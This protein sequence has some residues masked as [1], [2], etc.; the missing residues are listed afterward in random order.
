VEECLTLGGDFMEIKRYELIPNDHDYTL[1]VYLDPQLEEYSFEFGRLK[2]GPENIQQQIQSLIKERYPHVKITAAK[3]MAG[4]MLV[5]TIY[6]GT[7]VINT[8]AATAAVQVEQ[9]VAFDQ[10]TVQSGDTVY[11]IAKKFNVTV[12]SLKAVN[13]LTSNTIFPGQQ[14]KLPYYTYTVVALDTLYSIAKRYNSTPT[15]IQ[16]F[17]QLSSTTL[18]IGQKLRIPRTTLQ[19]TPAAPPTVEQPGTYKVV[20]GDTLY[21]I[22]KRFGVTL[23]QI[24]SLNRLTTNDIF[25]GQTL[26]IKPATTADTVAPSA[27]VMQ[28]PGKITQANSAAFP[29]NGT[30]EP[31]STVMITIS[32]GAQPV[33]TQRSTA[34]ER[35]EFSSFLNVS[36]LPDGNLFIKAKAIDASG[37]ESSE[38]TFT[39]SKDTVSTDPVIDNKQL[40]TLENAREYTIFGLAEPGATVEMTISDGINPAISTKAIVS[41]TG[42]FR[43][44]IDLRSLQDGTLKIVAR[45]IDPYGNKSALTETT[46]IKETSLAAPVIEN[47]GIINLESSGSYMIHGMARPG[48]TVNISVSDGVHPPVKAA[49]TTDQNGEFHIKMDL[50]PLL[51]GKL[52]FSTTQTSVSGIQ[53]KAG[54]IELAK[55]AT[56]P[57]VPI[58]NN[59]NMINRSNQG[60]FLLTGTA[61][62]LAMVTVRAFNENG[63]PIE[64]SVQA[65]ETG[66]YR[67]PLDVSSLLDG[68][69]KFELAQVDGAGNKSL[70]TTKTLKKDTIGPTSIKFAPIPVI[71]SGNVAGYVISGT[72]EPQ[73]SVDMVISDGK[74]KITKTFETD[75]NGKFTLLPMDLSSLTDGNITLTFRA[76]DAA[77]NTGDL[78]P[79]TVIKDTAAQEATINLPAPYV[80]SSTQRAF[81]ISGK[82]VED[83][84]TVNMVISDGVTSVMKSTVVKNG[85]FAEGFDL[86]GLKDGKLTLQVTTTDKAGNTSVVQSNTIEKDTFVGSP[87]VS[88]NGLETRDTGSIFTIIGTAEPKAS[89]TVTLLGTNGERLKSVTTVTND[90][91]FYSIQVPL[92]GLAPV[93]AA[94]MLQTDLAGNESK[95]TSINLYS[96]TVSAGET[97]TAIAKR[98]NTTVYAL[99]SL[100]NLTGDFLAINQTLRLP[101]TASEVVNLGY[102]Y[103]DTS[104]YTDLVSQTSRSINT[105]SPSYFDIN[106]DGTLKLTA[107]IDRNF[108]EKMHAQGI[109]VVPFLSNHWNREVGRAMLANKEL[110][111]TQIADAVARY[112]LDGVH[113]DIENVTHLDRAN[114]TE[115]VR[116]LR[117]KIPASK[118]VSVAVA[119][120]PNGW[121]EGWHGSYDYKSLAKYADYLMIMSYD[122]SYP[123]GE[124]GPVASAPWVERSIQYAINNGVSSDKI[125][126]GMSHFGRYWIAGQSYGGFGISNWQVEDLIKTYNGTVVWDEKSQTPKAVITIKAGDPKRV[127]GGTTLAPGTYTIWFDNDQSIRNK[128]ALVEKYGLRGVGNWSIGQESGGIWDNFAA[129]LPT[130][131]P[132]LA[133]IPVVVPTPAP[134]PEPVPTPT[135]VPAPAPTVTNID[136]KVISGDTLYSIANRYGTSVNAIKETNRLTSDILSV[137]QILAIPATNIQTHTVVS[138]DTLYSI[139]RRYNT[140]V[141][142]IK[143]ENALTTDILSIGQKLRIPIS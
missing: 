127:I 61:D 139:A 87:S 136:Y 27:P 52:T 114:Y 38:S 85:S 34:N 12:D 40:V 83:G 1:I 17:N 65:D 18:S 33:I 60:S 36:T 51:D 20:A 109:R 25:I 74:N 31:G 58:L 94:T 132:G 128:L 96:H 135:P 125:V 6:F 13:G 54:V 121:T 66:E 8:S 131:V 93:T 2:E 7:A 37:N 39:V 78:A 57:S 70:L 92:T 26:L 63:K 113:V 84:S 91:G 126:M 102:M 140:T 69:V 44:N 19:T 64:A 101:V 56:A 23:D 103:F 95:V 79:I 112:N 30:S 123:G 88:K 28:Q 133:S 99:R 134:V 42:E 105:V 46:L 116:L 21:S 55:D 77:G 62:P 5:T 130:T 143:E 120:N 41:D 111:T 108:I 89:V 141:T 3:V 35:G 119:A 110:A 49:G 142:K 43:T 14:L 124:A 32:D 118:E 98:Y 129:V 47:S 9:Q 10:Y 22:A 59:N 90:V 104:D 100:N 24:K 71:F 48:S 72:A 16:T 81:I 68:D 50:T 45:S 107:S 115:F 29:V 75:A 138:G 53:S 11:G 122:E 4:T 73:I 137:G 117:E 80:N 15:E 67:L 76:T 82:H 86:S 97:L 106:G